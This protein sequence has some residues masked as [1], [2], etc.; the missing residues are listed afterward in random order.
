MFAAISTLAPAGSSVAFSKGASI[1]VLRRH[2]RHSYRVARTRA[3]NAFSLNSGINGAQAARLVL[4]HPTAVHIV[5]AVIMTCPPL[6]QRVTLLPLPPAH[7]LFL[8]HT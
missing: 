4:G 2:S 6:T 8:C 5:S 3:L 1:S 7:P